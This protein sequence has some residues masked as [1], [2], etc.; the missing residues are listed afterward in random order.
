[1]VNLIKEWNKHKASKEKEVPDILNYNQEK[2]IEL[3]VAGKLPELAQELL[4]QGREEQSER[5]INEIQEKERTKEE[6]KEQKEREKYIELQKKYDKEKFEKE[7]KYLFSEFNKFTD[8]LGIAKIF[9]K[10]Q[11]V[12]YDKSRI[13]W[14]WNNFDKRWE[15]IDETDL[16]NAIDEHTQYPTTQ[17]KIKYEILESLKRIGRKNKPKE[18]DINWIQFK[19]KI[20]NVK[21]KENFLATPKYFI[22][23]PIPHSVGDSEETPAMDRIMKEWVYKEGIQDESYIRTLQEILSYCFLAAMPIHRIFCFIGEGLNGKGTFLR[24]IENFVGNHNKCATE[25]ELITSNR[26]ESSK[27][28]KKLV[29]ITGEIDKGIFNK[30]KT[31]KS[32]SGEDLIRCE[33]KGKDGFDAHNYAKILIST[34]HLPETGDKTKGFYRRWTIV[35]FPNE[36]NE[37][38][39][40]LEDIPEIE[41]SNFCRKALNILKELLDR[42]D[43]TNDGSIKQREN[44]YEKHSNYINEFISRFCIKDDQSYIEFSE[45]YEKYNDFLISE[46]MKRKSKMEISKSL[47]IKG[48][49]KR[50]KKVYNGIEQTTKLCIFGIKFIETL[51]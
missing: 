48:F 15:M 22:T 5:I 19:D 49:D 12:F 24:L 14:L 50:V 30:T 8:F 39:N 47:E 3:E 42:G 27:L 7:S 41:Y 17:G 23:N 32:L 13:W 35:D 4:K 1:M 40:I 25:I 20:Y 44:K 10:Y 9:I 28:H 38:K 34:N 36:F 43:F 2:A 31:L 26:F 11:P 21:T 33:I 6:E 16:L 18:P 29:C 46:G 45:F 51:V 37:K